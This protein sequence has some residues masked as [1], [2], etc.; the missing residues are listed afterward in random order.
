MRV[1]ATQ[2]NGLDE[3]LVERCEALP[4]PLPAGDYV[5]VDVMFFSTTVVELL[6]N[7]AECVHVPD[8]RGGEFDF[9]RRRPTALVGG[10]P[11]RAYEPADGYDFFNSPSDVQRL[12]VEGR[13]VSMTSTNGG[14]TV[15]TLRARSDNRDDVDVFVGSTLNAAAL[16][17][18]LR[19]REARTHLVSAG[20]RG[21][22]AV[23]DHIGATLVSRYLDDLAPAEAELDLFREHLSVAKGED[24]TDTHECRRRDVRA[25][26]MDV[27]AR[28]VVP[29][30]D[31]DALV[32]AAGDTPSVERTD[33]IKGMPGG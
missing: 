15:A 6:A 16:A 19:G 20:T 8:E 12:P 13:P 33:A 23:E 2:T 4:D 24:Y 25:Y 11:T 31:G 17:E 18:H 30:L 28:S 22:V 5:V 32:D 21:S 3:R 10:E 27:N 26:A 29:R 9:R 1:L 14:R 7:G